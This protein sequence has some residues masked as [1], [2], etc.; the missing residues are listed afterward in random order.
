MQL[1]LRFKPERKFIIDEDGY[2]VLNSRSLTG[3]WIV[4]CSAEGTESLSSFFGYN[5]RSVM[6]WE[7]SP[8][9]NTGS[10]MMITANHVTDPSGNTKVTYSKHW[11]DEDND[12]VNATVS[13]DGEYNCYFK[14][15]GAV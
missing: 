8:V 10:D 1:L 6:S 2:L 4:I 11:I 5:I 14:R 12:L 3:G 15:K 9:P 7:P 13:D